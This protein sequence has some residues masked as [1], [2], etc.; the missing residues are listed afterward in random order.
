MQ[1]VMLQ[2]VSFAAAAAAAAFWSS[3]CE[4]MQILVVHWDSHAWKQPGAEATL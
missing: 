3:L 2:D 4:V 1:G